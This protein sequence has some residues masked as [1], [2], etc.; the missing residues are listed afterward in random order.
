LCFQL[1]TMP[2]SCKSG[3]WKGNQF[4]SLTFDR[5]TSRRAS[6]PKRDT[7]CPK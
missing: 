2:A 7:F 1:R 3:H 4:A 6:A 5:Q